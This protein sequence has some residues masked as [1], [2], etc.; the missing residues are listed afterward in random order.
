MNI[1]PKSI[2]KSFLPAV[3]SETYF[4]HETLAKYFLIGA[5]ASA[6]DVVLFMTLFLGFGTS[7]LF[8]HSVSVPVAVLFSFLVNARHNFRVSDH[9]A[10]RLLSF[11][12]VC[13]V[14]Y[15]SGYAVILTAIYA[16]ASAAVGK[17]LS[18][19]IVFVVQYIL[20]SR[21]TFR[22]SP[23]RAA[24]GREGLPT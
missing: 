21:I 23:G 2:K 10:L 7:P 14:G 19:P 17:I 1:D 16:G 8:A 13:I 11:V 5:T 18:L 20:N 3:L 9:L 15:L 12:T 6:I 4:R 22:G 24:T